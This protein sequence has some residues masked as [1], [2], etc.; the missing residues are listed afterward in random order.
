MSRPAVLGLDL[1]TSGVKAVLVGADGAVLARADRGYALSS[2]CAG[3]A[4][5]DPALWEAAAREAVASVLSAGDAEIRAV[6]LDGQMHGTVLV[7]NAGAPVRPAVLWA[8]GRATEELGAWA[9][10]PPERARALANP[11]APGMTGPVLAWLARHEP[12]SIARAHRLL[13][14][15]DWL[16]TWLVPGAFVTDPS[17]ASATLLWDLEQ[18]GWS[19]AV[20]EATGIPESLL[21]EVVPSD[22]VVGTLSPE[23]AASWGLPAGIPVVAGCADAA[24]TLVGSQAAPGRLVVTVGSGAQ[25]VLPRVEPRFTGPIRHHTYRAADGGAYAMLAVMNA[26]IALSRVVELLGGTWGDLYRDYDRTRPVP[27]FVPFLSG[28]RLPTGEPAGSG[29]WFGLGLETERRD[30]FAAALEG[31]CFTIRRG[32]ESIPAVDDPVIDVAGGGTRS[33]VLT[34]LLADVLGRRLRRIDLED[35]TAVGA[36]V[37]GFS[38][39]GLPRPVTAPRGGV[40]VEPGDAGPLTERYARFLAEVGRG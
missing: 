16:R 6:G 2:P 3:W 13:L 31:L 4:E 19:S 8:D 28:E 40:V 9:G 27:G 21:P 34:Q 24:A 17:D 15:K 37:L 39:A 38:A 10:L 23:V 33:P 26:G 12:D 29:R 20:L 5:T 25:V 1:G 32:V 14:P 18:D 11:L 35:A 36:A 30:L 22:S 7:D